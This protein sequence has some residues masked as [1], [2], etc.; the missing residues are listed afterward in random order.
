[1][2]R[3]TVIRTIKRIKYTYSKIDNINFIVK[4]LNEI[5]PYGYEIIETG[6]QYIILEVNRMTIKKRK[7]YEV[8]KEEKEARRYQWKIKLPH[9]IESFGT[10]KIATEFGDKW[11]KTFGG[12]N[13]AR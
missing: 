4:T 11:Q 2:I 13:Y 3:G 5:H 7:L 8:W 9:G 6:Y 10:K 12:N 1:M